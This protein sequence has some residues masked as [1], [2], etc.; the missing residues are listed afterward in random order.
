MVTEEVVVRRA[1]GAWALSLFLV[2]TLM[3]VS[4][5]G[6]E[7][8]ESATGSPSGT[9]PEVSDTQEASLA[10][11]GII[12]LA[13]T[14]TGYQ[15]INNELLKLIAEGA[16]DLVVEIIPV[17]PEALEQALVSG[18]VDI[19]LEARTPETA[20]WND[21]A[22]TEGTLINLG[23]TY[24]TEDE[25]AVQK[26]ANPTFV[27]TYPELV[28]MLEKMDTRSRSLG[29]TVIW[30]EKRGDVEGEEA[31]AYYMYTF[32]F[33]DRM[34]SWMP[35]EKYKTAKTYMENRYPDFRRCTN[36]PEPDPDAPG[37]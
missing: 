14:G 23:T 17:A 32:D 30:A 20:T 5:S 9:S 10:P 3:G 33:E 35:F 16:F 34:K 4:C 15:W 27:E 37:G 11:D 2:V 19:H 26:T 8:T 18:D 1:K 7:E 21:A 25:F 29:K 24:E 28:S 12:R 22:V 31:A 13:D 36:C 6:T